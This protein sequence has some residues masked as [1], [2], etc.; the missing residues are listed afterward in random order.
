M[1]KGMALLLILALVLGAACA[2]A[3][4]EDLSIFQTMAGLEWSFSSGAGAW[5]TELYIQTDGS[6]SGDF[7]DS[8]M[9]DCTD[10]YPYGTL[11]FCAFSGRMSLV[12]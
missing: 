8:D 5:S 12:E 9:G 2:E 10:E 3:F 7:H 4:A 1:K 11:Y 6:F